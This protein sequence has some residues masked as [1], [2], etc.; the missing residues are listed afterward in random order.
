[1]SGEDPRDY[2]VSFDKIRSVVGF[3]A[4][5]RVAEG[6]DQISSLVRNGLIWDPDAP[7]YS[8]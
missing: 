1:M 4:R 2:R 8:N 3:V 5:Y 6:I 7:L